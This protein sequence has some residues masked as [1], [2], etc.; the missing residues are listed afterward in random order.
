MP[1][2]PV[3]L[4]YGGLNIDTSYSAVPAG[5]TLD[6]LNVLPYD[7]FKGKFRLGQRKA[8]CGAFRP[9]TGGAVD[10]EVQTILRAD[11]YVTGVGLKQRC[12]VVKGGEVYIIDDGV[13]VTLCTRGALASMRTTGPISAA[14]FGA[15]CYFA[16]GTYYRKIGITDATPTV[17]DWSTGAQHPYAHVGSGSNRATLLVRFG[18]RL[19]M[20]GVSTAP[21]NW[22]LCKLNDPD[23][24]NPVAGSES[25]VSGVS[26]TKYGVPG[27]PITALIPIGES[28]LLFAGAHSL[29]YLTADPVVPDARLIEL[30]R[31]VGIIS[32]NAW[33]ATDEQSTYVMA[34]DG[35][36]R[37]TP[38]DF[39]ITKSNRITSNRL[40]TFFQAQRFQTLN[41]SLG[42][43]AEAQNVFIVLSRTDL[44]SSS[45]HLIYN[46]PTNSFWPM[47]I[48]WPSFYAPTC[49]GQFPFGTSRA[50]ILA[51]GSSDGYIGW[52]DRDLTSGVDGQ[53]ANGYKSLSLSPDA[54]TQRINSRLTF[55]PLI[56]P[57][58]A[59]VM[60]KDIRVELT[61]DEPIESAS[62]APYLSGPTLSALSGE[63]AEAA[64]GESITSVTV[65]HDPDFPMVIVDAGTHALAN[66]GSP[67]FTLYDGGI[68]TGSPLTQTEAIDFL[69][70]TEIAGTYTTADTLIT[71][72]IS[73]TYIKNGLRVY[74]DG[75][76]SID[77][78]I[79][80]IE[81]PSPKAAFQRD[82]ALPGAAAS[83]PAGIYVYK[84]EQ[85]RNLPG[86]SAL[87]A[88]ITAPRMI[89]N[90]AI[91][92][93]LNI[94]D[95]GEMTPGSNDSYRCRIRDQSIFLRIESAGVPWAV[96][97]MAILAEQ[98]THTNDV[99][100]TY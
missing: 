49:C 7:A 89:V 13:T 83:T 93:P 53:A 98:R 27:E 63:T 94:T 14:V 23:S 1:Y 80:H 28:G 32:Q 50:P 84:S 92:N 70:E 64:I 96:E 59:E 62:Y 85:L 55:G 60:L 39:Q 97:R 65:T 20:S 56:D 24:W 35:L 2:V 86:S 66:G 91:Y 73:R 57:S 31:S 79:Q 68:Q 8:F 77:W 10:D 43:D 87:P 76:S 25:A 95:F 99:K 58:L 45:I 33:C 18:G 30:S 46:Q 4:P 81:S 90:A 48:N 3:Q 34:Q 44:P 67:T 88:G 29:T 37:I 21:N 52:F 100:R 69:F 19:A 15:Y 40:N 9:G 36:Y 26:S 72:P 71:D 11:A 75:G 42:Y 5:M 38:N 51:F 41:C 82:E 16:D 54:A 6:A 17:T 22:F 12:I 78:F 61:M 47:K 74:N